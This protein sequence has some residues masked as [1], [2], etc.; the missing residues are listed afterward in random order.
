MHFILLGFFTFSLVIVCTHACVCVWYVCVCMYVSLFLP[1]PSFTLILVFLFWNLHLPP[2]AYICP[3]VFLLFTY[4]FYWK[5]TSQSQVSF[6]LYKPELVLQQNTCSLSLGLK[7]P[8]GLL[9]TGLNQAARSERLY[10]PQ[11]F[12]LPCDFFQSTTE[13]MEKKTQ[14]NYLKFHHP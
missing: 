14:K 1:G 12:L 8:N 2:R 13:T 6:R 10:S 4:H 5:Y 9:G 3:L 11:L 7:V